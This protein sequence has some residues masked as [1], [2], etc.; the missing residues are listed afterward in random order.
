MFDD[1]HIVVGHVIEQYEVKETNM[2]KYLMLVKELIGKFKFYCS[3]IKKRKCPSRCFVK[4]GILPR[5]VK[6]YAR[7][8]SEPPKYPIIGISDGDKCDNQMDGPCD[9]IS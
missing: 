7:R 1:S 5:W 4:N 2:A 9:S 8:T 6:Q 3:N